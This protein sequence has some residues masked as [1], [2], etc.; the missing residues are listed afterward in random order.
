MQ[1]LA[2]GGAGRNGGTRWGRW[3]GL[4]T[5]VWVQCIYGKNYTI[6]N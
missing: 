4:V 1:T 2:G 6:F 3:L 5:A